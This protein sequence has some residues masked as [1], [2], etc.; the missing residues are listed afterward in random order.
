M[1]S[2]DLGA[3]MRRR[4]FI[5][6]LGGAAVAWPLAAIAQ[7]PGYT[8]G[9]PVDPAA[10]LRAQEKAA[11]QRRLKKKEK[12]EEC[13]DRKDCTSRAEIFYILMR[14]EIADD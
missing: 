8:I 6:L 2:P 7:S 11:E 1:P 13:S 9:P 4:E 14:K 5:T 10:K 12:S 3:D